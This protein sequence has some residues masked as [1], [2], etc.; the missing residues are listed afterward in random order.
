MKA[1]KLGP[2]TGG[3]ASGSNSAIVAPPDHEQRHLSPEFSENESL[4]RADL[5]VKVDRK[6]L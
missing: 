5:P 6:P 2:P 1:G 4:S 3:L